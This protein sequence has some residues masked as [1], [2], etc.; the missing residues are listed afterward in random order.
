[1]RRLLLAEKLTP[2]QLAKLNGLLEH[3]CVVFCLPR[4]TM[5]HMYEPV[6]TF[7][8]LHPDFDFVPSKN[9][10]KQT[11]IWL[12]RLAKVAGS[13]CGQMSVAPWR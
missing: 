1:M 4:S 10:V 6:Q 13:R 5:F 7:V 12:L 3:L 11:A 8:V 2:G 9:L